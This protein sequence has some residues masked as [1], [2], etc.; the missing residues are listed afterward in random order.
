VALLSQAAG[1]P[2]AVLLGLMF[3][4]FPASLASVA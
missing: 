3:L 1:R 2:S 4:L